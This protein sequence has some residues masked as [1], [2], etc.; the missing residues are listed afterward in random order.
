[1]QSSFSFVAYDPALSILTMKEAYKLNLTLD[2]SFYSSERQ[3][4]RQKQQ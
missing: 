2:R 4:Q 1:M 3:Q